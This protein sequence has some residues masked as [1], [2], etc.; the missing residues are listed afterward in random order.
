MIFQVQQTDQKISSGSTISVLCCN[1][2]N[3]ISEQRV[4]EEEEVDPNP[5]NGD[6]LAI[7]LCHGDAEIN[8]DDSSIIT[9]HRVTFK[10]KN[11]VTKY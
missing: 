7:E 6:Q 10:K 4:L 5:P 9:L 8:I 2:A 3:E 11:F 1:S